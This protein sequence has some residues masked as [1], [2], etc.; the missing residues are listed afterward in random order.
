MTPKKAQVN[1][2][3]VYGVLGLTVDTEGFGTSIKRSAGSF[4]TFARNTWYT[5]GAGGEGHPSS[6]FKPTTR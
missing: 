1:H 2:L 6:V 4:F 3:D 5:V